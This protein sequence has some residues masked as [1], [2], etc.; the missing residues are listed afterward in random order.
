MI[1]KLLLAL[2]L[3]LASCVSSTSALALEEG[4][5]VV[6]IKPAE[7]RINL[8]PGTVLRD[9]IEVKNIGR[10]AFTFR[11]LTA[12]YWV[13]RSDYLPDFATENA[14]TKM[15]NWISFEKD[16]YRLGAG[17]AVEVPFQ[18]RVPSDVPG[19]GQYAAIIFETRDSADQNESFRTINRVASLL[20]A[21]VEGESRESGKIVSQNLPGFFLGSPIS[22]DVTVQN[23]GNLDFYATHTLAVSDFFTGRVLLEPNDKAAQ[24]ENSGFSDIMLLPDTSRLDILTWENS[25]RLGLFRVR[26]TVSFLQ[27]D[28][29]SERVVFVCPLW[30]IALVIF[31]VVLAVIW[32]ILRIFSRKRKHR[33]VRTQS[34]I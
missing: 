33:I 28:E 16:E 9:T 8:E 32:I 14:Y 19:G 3:I 17:D 15:H 30:L 20:Y 5:I 6:Q 31:F 27:H 1:K 26:E 12:P 7:Q 23:D 4:D 11:P 10:K 29:V 21:K 25:P 24:E 22:A 13:Q 2:S 18:I 34:K